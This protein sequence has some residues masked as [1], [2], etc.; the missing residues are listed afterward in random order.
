VHLI[1]DPWLTVRKS[2]AS[3]HRIRPCDVVNL[4]IVDVDAPRAD[5]VVAAR[6]F[7]IGLLTTAGLLTPR[8]IG[9][10]Y[11]TTRPLPTPSVLL[12]RASRQ[13]LSCWATAT[14]SVSIKQ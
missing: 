12:W 13:H 14:A 3:R 6:T 9:S 8:V 10:G 11:T 1:H 4:E 7:L 5:L 2:D